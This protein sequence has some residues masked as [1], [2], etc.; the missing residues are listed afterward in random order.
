MSPFYFGD[1]G[2]YIWDT[3]DV[4]S[5]IVVDAEPLTGCARIAS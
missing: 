4:P 2:I 5:D 3:A 1:D